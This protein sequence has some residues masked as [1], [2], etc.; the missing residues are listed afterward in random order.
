M[1]WTVTDAAGHADAARARAARPQG[2]AR[3]SRP[4]RPC[5]RRLT[6]AAAQPLAVNGTPYRGKLVVS[7]DGKLVQVIDAVGLEQYLKGVV[8]AEMP[9]DWPAEALK[10]QAV[11]ARSYALANLAAA[12]PFDLYGD[13]RSQAYGGTQAES[14]STNAAVDAT[15][16]RGRALQRQG[17]GHA[18]SSPRPAGAPPRRSSPLGAAVPYLVSVADPYDTLSPYHDWGPVVMDAAKV[19]KAA[20][21][22]GAARRP[23]RR[24]PALRAR[25]QSATA[26]SADDAQV[27]LTGNQVRTALGLR[28]TWFSPALL[29]LLPVAKTMTYGGAV[30]LTRRRPR[31]RCRVARVEDRR[32]RRS[33]PPAGDLVPEP[34]VRSRRSSGRRRRRSTGSPGETCAPGSPRIAVAPRVDATLSAVRASP[35]RFAPSSPARRC[36]CRRQFGAAW[37]TVSSTVTDAARSVDLRRR[38]RAR[39]LPRPLRAGPR[40]SP[41]AFP[42]ADRPVRRRA[43]VGLAI[44][45]LVVPAAAA[46]FDSTEPLAAHQW[47]LANDRAWTYWATEP[48]LVPDQRRRDRLGDRRNASRVRRPRRRR[49]VV[50][51][52][53]AVSR[54]SGP[55][56][57]RRRRDRREPVQ[58]RG[59]RRHGLQRPADG[60]EGRRGGRRRVAAGRRSPRSAGRSTTARA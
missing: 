22:L 30:S 39:H 2:S 50:R 13:T 21:A 27:T 31:C 49:E 40:A 23:A 48:Q 36:S 56:H 17:R 14:A 26:V 35:G 5:S 58:R 16:G 41:P 38:A 53:L 7:G 55:R 44:A 54:R 29:E 37:T 51:R 32:R 10:A 43:A 59:H 33:G 9:S 3:C 12:R 11:A 57:L 46:A 15:K 6:F 4:R 28:S 18:C 34:T 1:P 52:R 24:R 60:R 19:A 20:E 47:Y 42:R 45:A 8:P 25:V